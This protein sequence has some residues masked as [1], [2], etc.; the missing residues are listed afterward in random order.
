M[1]G[2][3]LYVIFQYV[4]SCYVVLL[5]RLICYYSICCYVLKYCICHLV[6]CFADLWGS[7]GQLSGFGLSANTYS[8]GLDTA[9]GQNPA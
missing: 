8:G 7:A 9:D 4:V 2:I 5:R 6:L 3:D 1:Y